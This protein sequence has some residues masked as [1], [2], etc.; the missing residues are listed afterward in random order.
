MTTVNMHEAKTRLSQLVA[1]VEAG[2]EIIISRDGKPVAKLTQIDV[3]PGA[4]FGSM[5]DQIW[6]SPAFDDPDPDLEHFFDDGPL[7]N[8]DQDDPK[9][10]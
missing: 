8:L 10:K 2:E 3:S 7:V 1:K 9:N 5:K 4:K 6:I